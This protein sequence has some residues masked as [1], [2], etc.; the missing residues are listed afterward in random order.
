MALMLV[1]SAIGVTAVPSCMLRTIWK[2]TGRARS[3]LRNWSR[4]LKGGTAFR[5]GGDAT[6]RDETDDDALF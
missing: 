1:A 2:D 4:G 5:E 3:G 6:T